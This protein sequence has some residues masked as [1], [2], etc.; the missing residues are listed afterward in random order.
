MHKRTQ[1]IP[2][3]TYYVALKDDAE[4]EGV[5]MP[6]YTAAANMGLSLAALRIAKEKAKE[7]TE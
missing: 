4:K 7:K 2:D 6:N 3:R 1:S 5:P